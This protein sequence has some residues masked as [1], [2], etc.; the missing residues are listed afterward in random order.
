MELREINLTILTEGK[1][2]YDFIN[3]I[4]AKDFVELHQDNFK[5]YYLSPAPLDLNHLMDDLDMFDTIT[6]KYREFFQEIGLDAS[7]E[8]LNDMF[9]RKYVEYEAFGVGDLTDDELEECYDLF[10]ELYGESWSG[11]GYSW[12]MYEL[13]QMYYES[14]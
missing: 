10:S 5:D 7:C 9:C 4:P 12:F 11:Y 14:K 1:K 6:E 2:V 13:L 8:W 3:N